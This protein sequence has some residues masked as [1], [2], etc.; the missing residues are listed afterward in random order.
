MRPMLATLDDPPLAGPHLVYEPKY[1]GIRALAAVQPRPDGAQVSLSSRLGNDKTA[2]FPEVVAALRSWAAGRSGA[3]ILDGEIV[4]LGED[5]RPVTFQRLQDRIHLAAPRDIA[6]L[7]AEKPAAF[8]VFDLLLDGEE[9]LCPLPLAER[10]RRLET[11][12]GGAQSE[13]LRLAPQTVG[14][15]DVLLAQA[16]AEGWEGLIV[17]DA[18]SPYR[19]GQRSRDW[20]KLKL[21]KQQEFVIGGWTEPRGSRA[22]FGALLLGLPEGEGGRLRYVGHSGGGFTD[23]ELDRVA[24]LLEA[25]ETETCPFTTRPPSNERPHWVRPEIVAEVKFSEWTDEGYLRH[26]I[27]L[28]LRDDVRPSEIRGEEVPPG[29]GPAPA[30]PP[31]VPT[32]RERARLVEAVAA[33]EERPGGGRLELPDGSALD[34]TNLRKV[35]WPELGITKGELLRYYVQISPQILPVV[36]DRPL[37]MRRSPDGVDRPSFYQ[38]RAPDEVPPGVRVE[39]VQDADEPSRRLVGGSL[40]TL[41]YM[42]QLGAIS[43]DPWFSRAGSPAEMDFAAIDLDPM[44]EAPFATVLDVARW[45]RDELE[46]L[47]A[48]GFAKSSGSRGLHI[49]L[50][51][52]PGTPYQAGLLFCQMVGTLVARRHPRAATV[53]RAVGRRE[54]G[55]VYLDCLQNIRGKTLACAYSARASA[56]A[57]ASAPLSWAEIDDSAAPVEPRALT[58]RTLPAR[59]REIGDLWSRF[60][61]ARGVDLQAALERA[62]VRVS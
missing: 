13:L 50:P 23:R 34:L 4:A 16:R 36:R 47:G 8:V 38:H 3:A 5:G 44:P 29:P 1:D 43:Q 27:Y 51:M 10:R 24:R 20:R 19:P 41:L 56:H 22:R 14:R 52:R 42:T 62:R 17:K 60:R 53:E 61:R 18:R 59:V 7:A 32:G 33:L 46:A 28:G 25:R 57:G 31:A 58:I 26:P 45:V 37:V 54:A 49:Y 48:S 39:V 15:G 11:V 12:V 21:I 35:L 6:R 2:Q 55:A 9:D 40:A 30:A